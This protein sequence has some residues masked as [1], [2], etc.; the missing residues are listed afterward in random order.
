V[1][2]DGGDDVVVL[3]LCDVGRGVVGLARF[4]VDRA[5][6]GLVELVVVVLLCCEDRGVACGL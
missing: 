3:V 5:E 2:G 1:G 6:L 4:A